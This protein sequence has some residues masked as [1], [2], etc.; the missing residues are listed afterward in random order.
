MFRRKR[1]PL[2]VSLEMLHKVRVLRDRIDVL[3]NRVEER[4]KALFERLVDLESKGE[5]YLAKK[6][7]EEVSKLDKLLS[8][9]SLVQLVLEKVDLALQY[10][11]NMRKF[12]ELASEVN[13]LVKDL[14]KMPEFNIPDLSMV[15]VEF[16]GLVKELEDASRTGS[17]VSLEYS[18]P[19][20]G[21]V[22]KILEEAR[23]IVK[24]RLTDELTA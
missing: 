14:S 24:E 21:D 5:K 7:A 4:R 20:D 12:A 23:A 8:R 16:E 11:I 22:K 9:L 2:R 15:F 10:S 1:D 13:G 6:Y 18:P 3:Y 17:P 19:L